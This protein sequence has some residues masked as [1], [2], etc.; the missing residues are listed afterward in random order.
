[1]D[2]TFT[3]NAAPVALTAE[4][5]ETLL[6][7]LRRAGYWSVKHG[8]ESGDCGA[9]LVLQDGSPRLACLVPAARAGGC[10]FTTVEALGHTDALHPLQQAFLAG[11]AVQCGYC[12]PAMLLAA[13]AL[14]A[15]D[16]HPSEAAV[17]EALAGVLCRCTGYL[18]PVQAIA[19]A[20]AGST[21]LGAGGD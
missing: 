17:R 13:A 1:M 8:C 21:V 14:L 6:A 10:A 18:K 3:V 16:P 20:A 11:G 5:S 15:R 12:T 2:L 4:P 7:V 9:C 19:A